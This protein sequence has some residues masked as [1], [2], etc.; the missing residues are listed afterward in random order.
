MFLK[1]TFPS[2]Q[3]I[4][5]QLSTIWLEFPVPHCS[6]LDLSSLLVVIFLQGEVSAVAA[7]LQEVR[8]EA[9]GERL[10]GHFPLNN[11]H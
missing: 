1:N 3:L 9:W 8:W 2:L 6:Q 10:Q 11:A 7:R 4:A 5:E